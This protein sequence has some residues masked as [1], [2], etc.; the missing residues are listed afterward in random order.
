M[1]DTKSHFILDLTVQMVIAL[2]S[3]DRVSKII[4]VVSGGKKYN[5]YVNK[6]HLQNS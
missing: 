5:L 3:A 6:D 2:S 1:S 4:W